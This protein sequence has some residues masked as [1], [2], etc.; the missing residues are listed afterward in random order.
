MPHVGG[1]LIIKYLGQDTLLGN[2]LSL[3]KAQA[4]IFVCLQLFYEHWMNTGRTS[5]AARAVAYFFESA[6]VN[7]PLW[8]L[9]SNLLSYGSPLDTPDSVAPQEERSAFDRRTLV[10][11]SLLLS[12]TLLT[13]GHHSFAPDFSL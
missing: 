3:S 4:F 8:R 11:G 5:F 10:L 1:P 7:I 6:H 12:R 13:S 9:I 2:S